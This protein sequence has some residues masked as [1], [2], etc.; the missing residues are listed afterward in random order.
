MLV[1]CLSGVVAEG[2]AYV[3]VDTSGLL[4]AYPV[5]AEKSAQSPDRPTCNVR[6]TVRRLRPGLRLCSWIF[7]GLSN[8]YAVSVFAWRAPPSR[9]RR[10]EEELRPSFRVT[11]LEVRRVLDA[12]VSVS[13]GP[14]SVPEDAGTDLVYT[15]SRTGQPE[16]ALTVN[17]SVNGT[18]AFAE[19]YSVSGAASFDASSGSV[20]IPAG[21][22]SADVTVQ[23]LADAVPEENETVTLAV[24]S[25]PAYTIGN[26]D[27]ATATI[28]ND[29]AT[30]QIDD[31][32]V[33]EG[34][35][36]NT[37]FTFTIT[38]VGTLSQDIQVR[39]QTADDSATASSPNADYTAKSS[40]LTFRKDLS[41]PQTASF[42]V[43]VKGDNRVELDETFFVN[44]T[45]DDFNGQ[46]VTI[47]DAQAVGTILNDD[48]ATLSIT[49]ATVVEGNS[50]T[51]NLVF[52]LSLTNPVSV[53]L[54]IDFSTADGTAVAPSDYLGQTGREITIAA[55]TQ[56]V[57]VTVAVVGDTTVELDE[58]VVGAIANLRASDLAVVLGTTSAE[59]VI[60][61]DDAA[62]L[63]ITGPRS[64]KGIPARATWCSPSA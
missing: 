14:S 62:A 17:F 31:V 16:S 43:T 42:V 5:D 58:T 19:D 50:G 39:A 11:E 33:A 64:R 49:G 1:R 56:Q 6:K 9:R 12:T 55:N 8:T 41:T 48:E 35:A 46:A 60:R 47:V 27:S 29:D 4:T 7:G 61:N 63:S 30:L 26:D 10:L 24:V 53:P 25:D 52:T 32:S 36:G 34:D 22:A 3:F 38:L 28:L 21:S 13:V 51:S 45:E 59:G 40:I 37:D 20:T 54:L 57:E 18:A 44:L 23:I 2:D 15:F